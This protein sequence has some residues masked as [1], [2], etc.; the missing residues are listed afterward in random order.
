MSSCFFVFLFFLLLEKKELVDVICWDYIQISLIKGGWV[1]FIFSFFS[2][3]FF[4]FFL[5]FFCY[6]FFL[7]FFLFFL[8]FS[9]FF[10]KFYNVLVLDCKYHLSGVIW[11]YTQLITSYY[12]ILLVTFSEFFECFILKLSHVV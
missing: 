10:Q 3:L 12:W 2:F 11:Q 8:F 4:L 7:L 9:F 6:F 5:L 1:G